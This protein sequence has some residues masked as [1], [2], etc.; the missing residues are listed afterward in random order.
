MTKLSAVFPSLSR[1]RDARTRPL[2]IALFSGNYDCVRDGANRALNRLVAYLEDRA[3]AD[4]RIYS[5]TAPQK[6]FASVGDI[7]SVKSLCIPGRPEYRL[8]LG[9]TRAAREN[10]AGFVPDIVHLSAPD[11]LGRQAQ[12]YAR[13][14]GIP[15]VASLHTRFETYLDYYRLGMLRRPVDAYLARFYGDA[16]HILAPTPPIRDELAARFGSEKLSIWSRGVDRDMFGQGLRSQAFRARLGYGPDDVVPLFFG[17]L[18]L[19]KGLGV[20]ADAIAALR[21]RGHAVRPVV[22][23]EG[24]ARD[25]L[26]R[27]LPNV[28]FLG[29]LDGRKLGEA[30]ASADVLINPSVTEAFGNVNLEAMASGLAVVS[31]DVDSASALIDDGRTGLLVPPHDANA[32]ADAVASL[33]RQPA[34]LRDMRQSAAVAVDRYR[35]DAIL[36][37]VVRVYER[38]AGRDPAL[39]YAKV[40]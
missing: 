9:L 1:Y 18:V 39:L 7:F 13:S 10:L 40:A 36:A 4:V 35:W 30:V 22:I 19:E 14:A 17:R 25:W 23:G 3:G 37:D 20:F 31:A 8:A 12:K 2:R 5:P 28:T 6:A 33:I 34:R 24:P 16:D 27:R 38:L 32:Y 15:V 29:F 11:A 21:D 26:A